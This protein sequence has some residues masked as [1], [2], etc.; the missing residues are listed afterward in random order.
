MKTLHFI[1]DPQCGW[2]YAAAPL[3]DA[4]TQLTNIEIK[5]HGGGLFSGAK[6]GSLSVSFHQ[7][8][9][10]MDN[11]IT[12]LTGQ[13]FSQTYYSILLEDKQRIVDS[14]TPI[15]AL[16]AA[17]SLGINPL[18]MLHKMQ[19]A[20]FVDGYSQSNIKN[21]TS[22]ANELGLSSNGF[23]SAFDAFN[24][25]KTQQHIR[26]AG[27]MLDLVG[28]SGFPT[29]AFEHSDGAFTKL[30]HSRY[31]GQTGQWIAYVKQSMDTVD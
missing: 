30:D 2:C 4:L 20:Q 15:A 6:K 24:G 18:S 27:H 22:I 21:L 16:L 19:I 9:K 5:M 17:E 1:M 25:E 8:I 13:V 11:R 29:F 14:D 3:L 31:Y 10:E 23:I 26:Q 28:S 7:R 12:A